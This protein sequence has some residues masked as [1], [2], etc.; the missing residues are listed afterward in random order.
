MRYD[1]PVRLLVMAAIGLLASACGGA[2][3]ELEETRCLDGDTLEVCAQD[4]E[5]DEPPHWERRDCYPEVPF[6]TTAPTG[7][8]LCAVEAEPYA[9]CP[10]QS[11]PVDLCDGAA[12]VRCDQGLAVG[13]VPCEGTCFLEGGDPFCSILPQPDPLCAGLEA[14]CAGDTRLEC[15][16]GWRTA[17]KPCDTDGGCV[18]FEAATCCSDEVLHRAVCSLEAEQ[19][20]MCQPGVYD[21]YCATPTTA[22]TCWAGYVIQRDECT[23]QPTPSGDDP[24]YDHGDWAECLTP[25]VTHE[26]SEYGS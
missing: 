8:D 18:E 21:A 23:D 26:G 15:V 14:T 24:C 7:K 5:L 20:P 4:S 1:R 13:I 12:I 22:I 3:C 6:C 11:D 19:D 16:G 2:E 25:V 17:E 10:N 9:A